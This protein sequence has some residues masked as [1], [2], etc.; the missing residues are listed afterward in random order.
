MNLIVK[1]TM[2]RFLF[3]CLIVSF[4]CSCKNASTCSPATAPERKRVVDSFKYSAYFLSP[5][6]SSSAWETHI[7]HLLEVDTYGHFSLL[8]EIGDSQQYFRG[9]V[10]DSLLTQIEQVLSQHSRDTTYP[11]NPLRG[12]LYDG[13]T[14]ILD[15]RSNQHRTLIQ[16]IPPEAPGDMERLYASLDSFVTAVKENKVDRL[17]FQGYEKEIQRLSKQMIT[18]PPPIL[19]TTKFTPVK[20]R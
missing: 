1:A 14:Y 19:D 16:F 3:F 7:I 10:P 9:A 17:N 5:N 4:Y 2:H 11:F 20:V 18:Q 13:Y 8:R 15:Y 12:Y 6:F